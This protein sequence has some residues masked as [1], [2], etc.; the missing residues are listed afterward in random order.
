LEYQL[1]DFFKWSRS[2]R[3]NYQT[4]ADS[5]KK[6]YCT[7]L[8][9]IKEKCKKNNSHPTKEICAECQQSK[10][11]EERINN[12]GWMCLSRLFGI[13]IDEYFDGIHHGYE[14]FDLRYD[15]Y[16]PE[17]NEHKIGIHLKSRNIRSPKG[18]GRGDDNIKGLY[19][20]Y[21]YSIYQANENQLDEDI[22]GISIPNIINQD[23]IESYRYMSQCF[24]IPI[25]ILQELD[26]I[27]I[28]HRVFELIALDNY[29][30]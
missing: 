5:K 12:G 10:I 9:R 1:Q 24:N 2:A 29:S 4:P 6:N 13:A 27:R 7:I 14:G 23:V 3:I 15:D 18:V 26:W 16:D 21:C 20:Q 30:G 28:L 8:G 25:I 19:A 17:R 11:T 22:I